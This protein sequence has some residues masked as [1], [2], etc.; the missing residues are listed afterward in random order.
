MY[1]WSLKKG[2]EEGLY[3]LAIPT[4][5]L[6]AFLQQGK[7]LTT[8]QVQMGNQLDANIKAQPLV[9]IVV[10]FVCNQ[11][12]C[13]HFHHFRAIMTTMATIRIIITTTTIT[14]QTQSSIGLRFHYQQG[15]WGV[16]GFFF[17]VVI[18]GCT[19]KKG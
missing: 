5:W 3:C 4:L 1:I 10:N 8:N 9:V 11:R 12:C 7:G 18:F 6:C 13:H 2:V 15:L 19:H 14:N 16:G 17:L